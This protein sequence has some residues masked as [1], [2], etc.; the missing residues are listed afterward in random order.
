MIRPSN[1][2]LV[3]PP[4]FRTVN[5]SSTS[6][7]TLWRVFWYCLP[8]LPR[9]TISFINAWSRQFSARNAETNSSLVVALPSR[10]FLLLALFL[11]FV[12]ALADDFRLGRCTFL[13]GCLFFLFL[14]L[15]AV[16]DHLVFIDENRGARGQIDNVFRREMAA[17]LQVL[18]VQMQ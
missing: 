10:L 11:I 15:H 5:A 8:M 3:V 12:L 6:K 1:F 7:P 16:H 4:G 2:S 14:A 17:D 9:P 13:A 18:D